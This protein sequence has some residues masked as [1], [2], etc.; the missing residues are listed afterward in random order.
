MKPEQKT[1]QKA[2]KRS[3]L[4][5][6]HLCHTTKDTL[7][8]FHRNFLSIIR[9]GLLPPVGKQHRKL[10]GLQH[11][12]V[13]AFACSQSQTTRGI[14]PGHG[15][16]CI[17]SFLVIVIVELVLVKHKTAVST[18]VNTESQVIPRLLVAYC[19]SGPRGTIL[20]ALIYKGMMSSVVARVTVRPPSIFSFVQKSYHA[21]PAGR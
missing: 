1:P 13:F 18:R 8:K 10:T 11:A 20:P 16:L 9:H 12:F 14:I 21:V 6:L 19:T 17:S 3:L 5:G 2:C 15:N 4:R 7:S